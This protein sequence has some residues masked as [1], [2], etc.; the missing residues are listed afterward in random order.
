M[1]EKETNVWEIKMMHKT[2]TLSTREGREKEQAK[3]K[4][5]K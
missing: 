3:L 1:E 2:I 4:R 5:Q